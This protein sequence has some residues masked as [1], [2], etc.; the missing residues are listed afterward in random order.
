LTE[1][2]PGVHD[3]DLGMVHAFLYAERDRLTLIDTGLDS[4]AGRI[5][6]EIEAIG[7]KPAELQQI[8][9]THYHADH[10]GSLAELAERTG[11]RVLVHA[12][13]APV[14]RGDVPE[15]PPVYVT[16]E[17]RE[18]GERIRAD[19]T[20]PRRCSIDCELADRDE[21]D[22]DGGAI[23][24]H[25]PGHTAGS[26]ALFLPKRRVLFSGDAAVR[27]PDGRLMSGVFNVDTAQTRAS[28]AKLAELDFEIACFGH[29]APLDKDAS[30]EFGRLAEA[31]GS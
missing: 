7:R 14:V 31:R 10:T 20:P 24:V 5:L 3:I 12:L 4:H 11:A 21:F 26:I 22:L 8:F 6:D 30:T 29:G 25:V 1:T 17:E 2:L 16:D 28:F 15:P 18:F 9:I 27:G 19:V 23:A 13:D